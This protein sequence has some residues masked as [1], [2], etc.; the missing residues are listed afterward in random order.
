MHPFI[1]RMH[2]R[3]CISSRMRY[4][5][6]SALHKRVW[7]KGDEEL[8][9]PQTTFSVHMDSEVKKQFDAFVMKSE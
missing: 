9:M 8:F 6:D 3:G 7:N 1:D 5:R 4:L 2:L